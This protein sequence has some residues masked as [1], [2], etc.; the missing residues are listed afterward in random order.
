MSKFFDI[1]KL[2]SEIKRNV[3][4][5]CHKASETSRW[6]INGFIDRFPK[7]YIQDFQSGLKTTLSSG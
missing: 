5:I 2:K 7:N 3:L 4:I 1:L 6:E